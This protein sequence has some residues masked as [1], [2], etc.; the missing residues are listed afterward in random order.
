MNKYCEEI[1]F[2]YCN[3][4]RLIALIDK[5]GTKYGLKEDYTIGIDYILRNSLLV[6]P[7]RNHDLIKSI[8]QN[9]CDDCENREK[10]SI[11][12]KFILEYFF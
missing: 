1:G 4:Y 5:F 7:A 3:F 9:S 10:F 12:N 8:I 2:C 6:G 11:D